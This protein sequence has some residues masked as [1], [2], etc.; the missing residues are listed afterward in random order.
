MALLAQLI[1]DVVVH[2]FEI[3]GSEMTIG[4]RPNCDIVIDDSAVSGQHAKLVAQPNPFFESYLEV[5]LEDLGSTNGTFVLDLPVKGKT[6]LHDGDI[7]RIG[8]NT[9]K[10]IDDTE[11]EMERTVHLIRTQQ[12][13]Q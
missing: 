13:Q 4:R 10:F 1:D 2:K 9:F 11:Q 3:S 6:R 8:L 12:S 7:V 5:Y